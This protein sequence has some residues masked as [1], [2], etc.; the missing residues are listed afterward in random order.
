MLF[1]LNK[2]LMATA[3]IV[4]SSV[5][6]LFVTDS[7]AA[8]E[9]I[10]ID[11]Q[12]DKFSLP[13]ATLEI[14]GKKQNLMLDTGASQALHLTKEFMSEISGLVIDPEKAR[15]TDITG[16]VFFND[17]FHIPQLSINGMIFK[18]ITGVSLTPWG[19]TLL[20]QEKKL[21]TSMVMGPNLFKDKVVLID[22]KNQKLSVSDHLQALDVNVT[23]G[24]SELPL[25]LTQEGIVVKVSQNAKNYNMILDTGAS[26]SVF[27]QQ[28]LQS[29]PVILP[30][31]AL[32]EDLDKEECIVS[33]FQLDEKNAKKIKL[34]SLLID[35]DFNHLNADGLIGNNF[36]NQYAV[37]IDFP[38]K[39]LFIKD[40]A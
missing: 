24:W 21:P 35:G 31:G 12:F 2:H 20:G 23:D 10:H 29:P 30:C 39:R 15:S 27:W 8:E 34:N 9:V 5:T 33:T 37:L 26:A 40:N 7:M 14:D 1:S 25:R 18:D 3:F 36:F 32:R 6:S 11:F 4:F 16:K 19:V 22:Y 28:R 17:K 13:V 38:G